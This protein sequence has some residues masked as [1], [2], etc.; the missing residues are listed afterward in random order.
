MN[1]FLAGYPCQYCGKLFSNQSNRRRHAVLSCELARVA[2]VEPRKSR[3]EVKNLPKNA[4]MDNQHHSFGSASE[5]FYYEDG[6]PGSSRSTEPQTCPFPDCEVSHMRSAL[7]KRHLFE[8]HNVQNVSAELTPE[9]LISPKKIKTEPIDMLEIEHNDGE[10]DEHYP[11]VPPIKLKISQIVGSQ[12]PPKVPKVPKS[13]PKKDPAKI[14][15]CTICNEFKSN[16]LY[17]LGRHKKSCEKK[18]AGVRQSSTED[19]EDP[20]ERDEIIKDHDPNDTIEDHDVTNDDSDD[21]EEGDTTIEVPVD[22]EATAEEE[23]MEAN[24]DDNANA[25]SND[26]GDSFDDDQETSMIIEPETTLNEDP[27]QRDENNDQTELAQKETG[28]RKSADSDRKSADSDRKST[29]SDRKSADSNRKSADENSNKDLNTTEET[30]EQTV[31]TEMQE[32]L[33]ANE[34]EEESNETEKVSEAN[35]DA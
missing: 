22:F 1:F 34:E 15:L 25:G 14:H 5:D 24:Q 30:D 6:A 13:S 16:N 12:I 29:D 18:F 10:M 23:P 3:E 26:Q 33:V 4:K 17:I 7:L 2:G 32:K 28:N 27:D 11:K 8:D 31:E 21:D 20:N 35:K 9:M 19:T